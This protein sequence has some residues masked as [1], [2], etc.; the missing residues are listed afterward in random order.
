MH[1]GIM[2]RGLK[3]RTTG[4]ATIVQLLRSHPR[5]EPLGISGERFG[6]AGS[7]PRLRG[8]GKKAWS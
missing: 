5:V 4:P 1:D 2:T 6:N 7:L 3:N 8:G